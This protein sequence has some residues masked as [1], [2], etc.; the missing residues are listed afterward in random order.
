MLDR[1]LLDHPRSVGESYFQHQRAALGFALSLLQ[2]AGACFIHALVPSLFESTGSR[3]IADLHERM[4]TNRN[5]RRAE[6][7]LTRSAAISASPNRQSAGAL[8]QSDL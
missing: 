6:V 2:A 1:W 3:A 5:K 7:I 8:P 4:V